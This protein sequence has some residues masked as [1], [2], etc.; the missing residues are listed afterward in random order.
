VNHDDRQFSSIR[1]NL[2]LRVKLINAEALSGVL[3]AGARDSGIKRSRSAGNASPYGKT[4]VLFKHKR[5][6]FILVRRF[7][8]G[9]VHVNASKHQD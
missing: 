3:R 5:L 1:R 9:V 6:L 4:P 2:I 8:E 7:S